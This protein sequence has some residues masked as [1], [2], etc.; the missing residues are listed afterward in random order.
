MSELSS[1]APE[2]TAVHGPESAGSA[3]EGALN[4][5]ARRVSTPGRELVSSAVAVCDCEIDDA[6]YCVFRV[7]L[8]DGLRRRLAGE[9]GQPAPD[10]TRRSAGTHSGWPARRLMCSW[11]DCLLFPS[12]CLYESPADE[13][14]RRSAA[15]ELPAAKVAELW[16]DLVA[17]DAARA[18]WAVA[19]LIQAPDSALPFLEKALLPV[20]QAPQ[21]GHAVGPEPPLAVRGPNGGESGGMNSPPVSMLG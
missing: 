7:A 18:Q 17:E 11:T 10:R 8:P 19:E 14:I 3:V 9:G 21:G 20:P 6:N 5:L 12:L 2:Q 16:T 1:H 13:L 4:A 15:V